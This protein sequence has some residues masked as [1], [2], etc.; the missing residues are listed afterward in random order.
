MSEVDWMVAR[1]KLYDLRQQNPHRTHDELALEVGYSTSWVGKWL[2]RF[3]SVDPDDPSIFLSRS[4]ARRTSGKQ[5]TTVVEDAIVEIRDNPPEGLRRIP[6]PQTILYYLHKRKDLQEAGY[7]LPTSTSTVWTILDKHQRIFRYTRP[8]PQPEER[9]EPMTEWQIDF[10]SISTVPA[11]EGG[12]QQHVVETLNTVDKGTSI[13]VSAT[14]RADYHA[15][16]ALISIVDTLTTHGLPTHISFDRDPRFV[17]SWTA[18]EFPSAFMQFLYA[19]A[20]QPK[21]CPPHRPDKNAFVE[22]YHLNYQKECLAIDCPDTLDKVIACTE[23]YHQH[24]NHER[25]SQALSCQNQP[26]REAFPDAHTCRCLP[27][28]VDPDRW[29]FGAAKRLYK[30]RVNANGSIQI[31]GYR[32]YISKALARQ[33]VA[34]RIQPAEK[35]FQVFQEQKLVKTI[36]IKGLC[37]G[38]MP[39]ADYVKLICRQAVAEARK[40]KVK[41]RR[42]QQRTKSH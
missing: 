41:R 30:R 26:P 28:R 34:L 6:G 16:T 1:V 40:L 22:R 36:P 18:N 12:K 32:Y 38:E 33:Q 15:E 13:L 11:E 2:N 9:P 7:Y 3:N 17:G 8:K 37:H 25:P 39:L 42:R 23:A 14:P 20:I 35:E 24:Y 5:V 19:L 10:K 29:L 27:E 31:G 21:V 4:R